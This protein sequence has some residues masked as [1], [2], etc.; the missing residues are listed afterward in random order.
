[1]KTIRRTVNGNSRVAR[2]VAS[3]AR[4]AA[5][6]ALC[7]PHASSMTVHHASPKTCSSLLVFLPLL[8][9]LVGLVFLVSVSIGG[10]LKP[11]MP[12]A[13]PLEPFRPVIQQACW[14]LLGVGIMLTLSRIPLSFYQASAWLWLMLLSMVLI[15]LWKVPGLGTERNGA[16]RW[17]EFSVPLLGR[18]GVQPSEL[19]KLA[20]LLYFAALY[21]QITPSRRTRRLPASTWLYGQN[22]PSSYRVAWGKGAYCIVALWLVALVAI[23][24]QPDFGTM[25][26]VFALGVGVSFLGG[27]SVFKIAALGLLAML[28]FTAWV[29]LPHLTGVDQHRTGYR[30]ERIRA[31]L[32][33]WAYEYDRGFQ[34][35]RAQIAVGSGGFA[36]LALGEGREKRYLPAAENDYIFATI[37]EE[38]G[39]VGCALCIGLFAWLV[40]TLLS[41]ASR[42]P[43]R[44][45]RLFAG[46]LALWIGLQALINIGMA[47]GLLP[48]VGVP[49]PFI[50]AGGSSMLSLMA[51]L[52]IALAIARETR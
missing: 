25:V 21:S 52:G 10:I 14:V 18:V 7:L 1:M 2:Q 17:I 49:L 11:N 39:F 33:P 19:F 6:G 43:T 41:L 51:A 35:V 30:L 24:R 9:C 16:V 34:M 12:P 42:A 44:F 47:I 46:G 50:S 22:I 8:L 40:A 20:T 32:D 29:A 26:L 48:T 5:Q 27:A 38:T 4:G 3:D 37:A 13:S 23:E 31:M 15:A 36:R 45:G 28:G